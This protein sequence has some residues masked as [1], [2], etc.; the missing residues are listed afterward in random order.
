MNLKLLNLLISV[1]IISQIQA[2]RIRSVQRFN[3]YRS[4]QEVHVNH[5][6][7][8]NL[9]GKTGDTLEYGIK[10]DD[11]LQFHFS[12]SKY[13]YLKFNLCFWNGEV[14]WSSLGLRDGFVS[15]PIGIKV[16]GGGDAFS[17]Q[18]EGRCCLHSTSTH[19]S[20]QQQGCWL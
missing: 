1:K 9:K 10:W 17:L 15:L 3:E 8:S 14:L 4:R 19:Q 11:S 2:L 6:L 12:H 18:R 13:H 16:Y 5:M 7:L 20:M